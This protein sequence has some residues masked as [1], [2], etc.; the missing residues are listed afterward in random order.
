M[1]LPIP[2]TY[3][4]GDE[5]TECQVKFYITNVSKILQHTRQKQYIYKYYTESNYVT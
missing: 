2:N 4:P 3:K 5:E 1:W